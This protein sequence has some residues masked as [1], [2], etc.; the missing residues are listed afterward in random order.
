LTGSW[1]NSPTAYAYQWRRCDSAGVACSPVAGA[2]APSYALTS[3]DVGSTMRVEVTATN[4]Y[5]SGSATSD[6]TA[7]IADAPAP[8]PPATTTSTFTG[9]LNA[10]QPAKSFNVAVGAGDSTATLTFSKASSMTLK[11][12]A[13]DG[14]TVATASGPS[15]LRLARNLAPG[16]YR[17]VVSGSVTKGSASFSLRVDAAAP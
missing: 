3:A 6:Q 14:S 12:L 10:K 16:T 8:A 11:L 9:S 2:T 7:S 1:L 4:G 15:G 13:P 5:G 17:Y